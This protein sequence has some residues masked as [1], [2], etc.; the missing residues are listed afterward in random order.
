MKA[1]VLALVLGIFLNVSTF[2]GQVW[3]VGSVV[4][5]VI[6]GVWIKLSMDRQFE[7]LGKQIKNRGASR[8]DEKE[9]Q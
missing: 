3:P 8:G 9:D 6:M 2:D 1:V 7:E 5:I 4:A